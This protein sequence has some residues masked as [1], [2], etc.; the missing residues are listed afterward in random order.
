[1][2]REHHGRL[3]NRLIVKRLPKIKKVQNLLVIEDAD[4]EGLQPSKKLYNYLVVMAIIVCKVAPLSTWPSRMADVISEMEPEQQEA[5]GCPVDW[6]L[7][8][9]W[10]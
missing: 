3:W 6:Q 10:S 7:Q 9:L 2:L 8:Q 4:G 1:M 5:M